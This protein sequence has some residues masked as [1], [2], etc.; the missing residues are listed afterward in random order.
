ML[1]H[2][3]SVMLA[4]VNGNLPVS[5]L[6]YCSHSFYDTDQRPVAISLPF[7]S[8]FVDVMFHIVSAGSLFSSTVLVERKNH[9]SRSDHHND[10]VSYGL[11]CYSFPVF[12]QPP[13]N[14]RFPL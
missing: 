10:L 2:T 9:R 13:T 5:D 12:R 3:F 7:Y 4:V 1:M 6:N 14:N 11:F 8:Q